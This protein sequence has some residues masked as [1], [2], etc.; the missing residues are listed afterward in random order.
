MSLTRRSSRAASDEVNAAKKLSA[1]SHAARER[2]HRRHRSLLQ[3]LEVR[4]RSPRQGLFR[5]DEEGVRVLSRRSRSRGV[6]RALA[7]GLRAAQRRNFRQPQSSRR[8]PR[9][10]FRHRARPSRSRALPDPQPTTSRNWRNSASPPRA[11]TR[12]SRPPR[13]T[14][15]TCRRTSSPASASGRTTSTPTSPP[16]PPPAKPPPWTWAAKATS[17]TPWIFSSTPT[18][19]ADARPTPPR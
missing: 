16:S 17:S 9:K 8:D 5:R 7:A 6:L 14:R 1:K 13:R 15:C 4:S 12:R 10:T 3:R 18:C 2:L 19:K 11:A